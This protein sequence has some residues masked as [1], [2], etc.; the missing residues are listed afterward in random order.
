MGGRTS[1]KGVDPSPMKRHFFPFQNFLRSKINILKCRDEDPDPD[2][3]DP[4]IFVLLD[5][6]LVL[7]LFSTDPDPTCNNKFKLRRLNDE[8]FPFMKILE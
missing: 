6:N 5:L 8:I 7:L 1:A 4:L 3:T 2:R